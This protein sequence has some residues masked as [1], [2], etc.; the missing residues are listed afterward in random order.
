MFLVREIFRSICRRKGFSLLTAMTGVFLFLFLGIYI[1]NLNNIRNAL[2]T[3][4][5][6]LPVTVQITNANGSQ[7][8]GL[9][10]RAAQ[11]DAFAGSGVR[12]LVYTAQAGGNR[13]EKGENGPVQ[14]CDTSIKAANSLD[15]FAN[16]REEDFSFAK[17]YDISY[18]SSREPWCTICEQYGSLYGI[19]TGDSLELSVYQ[20][21]YKGDAGSFQFLPLGRASLKVIGVYRT[22]SELSEVLLSADWLRQY[23]EEQGTEFYYGSARG[24]LED[25]GNLNG[26]K[27]EMENS[28]FGEVNPDGPGGKRGFCLTVQDQMFIETAGRLQDNLRIYENFQVPFFFL[29]YGI[30]VL[31][32]FLLLRCRR[33]EAAVA[34]SLG[35]SR[36]LTGLALFGENLFLELAGC[37]AIL[38]FLL[39]WT[40]ISPKETVRLL[41]IYMI[42]L[43]LGTVTALAGLLKFDVMK[44]LAKID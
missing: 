3:L 37:V 17:G 24:V 2:E 13:E 44:L 41:G 10:I 27:K 1:G 32:P 28:A 12:D 34:L 4:G 33:K 40:G 14:E 25:S 18:L 36:R 15:A 38:P 20:I 5:E 19:E 39:A 43:C 7:D 22:S 35:R 9:E 29:I 23:T 11:F 42:C 31:L 6:K 8:I 21:K 16:L 30:S 26:F